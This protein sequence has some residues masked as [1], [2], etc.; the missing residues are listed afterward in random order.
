MGGISGKK[1]YPITS[2]NSR[3]VYN[4]KNR[5]QIFRTGITQNYN[6]GINY[7]GSDESN[8]YISYSRLDQKGVINGLSDYLRNTFRIN[9]TRKLT[10]WLETR[11]NTTY[12]DIK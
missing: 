1:H 2:K 4:D 8:T 12:I 10:S 3:D 5:N 9:N 6:L 7:S 11:I